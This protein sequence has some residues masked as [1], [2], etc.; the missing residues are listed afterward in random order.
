MTNDSEHQMTTTEQDAAVRAGIAGQAASTNRLVDALTEGH[1]DAD[2]IRDGAWLTGAGEDLG[3]AGA[4]PGDAAE[5]AARWNLW[6][7]EYRDR[8]VRRYVEYASRHIRNLE[9]TGGMVIEAG[10]ICEVHRE[11]TCGDGGAYGHEPGCGLVPI[12]TVESALVALATIGGMTSSTMWT[13]SYTPTDHPDR[14]RIVE[15]HSAVSAEDALDRASQQPG[16]PGRNAIRVTEHVTRTVVTMSE[17][18]A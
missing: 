15:V 17:V 13:A 1:P 11:C 8:F 12:A 10:W 3:F 9:E 5:F 18:Q 2:V 4:W 6:G 16:A 7:A 14:A